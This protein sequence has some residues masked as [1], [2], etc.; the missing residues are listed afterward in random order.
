MVCRVTPAELLVC[1]FI[2]NFFGAATP[3]LHPEYLTL[4]LNLTSITSVQLC[5]RAST[6]SGEFVPNR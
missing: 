1:P 3:V 2:G 4:G 5:A 6:D